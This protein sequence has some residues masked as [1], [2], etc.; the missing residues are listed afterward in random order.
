MEELVVGVALF[1][2]GL[3]GQQHLEGYGGGREEG[4]GDGETEEG[5]DRGRKV[6]LREL[7]L[8]EEAD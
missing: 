3:V 7:G 1:E 8:L 5:G 2:G 6:E 4:V